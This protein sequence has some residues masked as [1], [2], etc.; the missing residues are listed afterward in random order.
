MLRVKSCNRKHN[1]ERVF[2]YFSSAMN[3][4]Y[5]VQNVIENIFM[6]SVIIQ[7]FKKVGYVPLYAFCK[8]LFDI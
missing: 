2:C 7:A 1:S 6:L 5:R 8:S 4:N 3:S